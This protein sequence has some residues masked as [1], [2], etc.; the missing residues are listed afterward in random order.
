MDDSSFNNQWHVNYPDDISL[1][2]A[3]FG[4][5]MKQYS[6]D[7]PT[8]NFNTSLETYSPT[9]VIRPAKMLKPN[10]YNACKTEPVSNPEP[11]FSP[12]LLSFG[13]S[14][15]LNQMEMMKPKEEAVFGRTINSTIP[16]DM[17]VAQASFRDPN[18]EFKACQG[19]KKIS[20]NTRLSH[21]QDH[22][23]AERKRREKLSQRFIALS[24]VI[25]G[26][27]KMD[28]ASVLGDAIKYVKQL[29][30]RVKTL[31][32]AKRKKTIESVVLVKKSQ[33]FTTD[34]EKSS[35]DDSKG[36]VDEPLPE[37]EAR[38]CD[39]QVLIRIHCEKRSGV[40]EKIV[41]EIEKLHL[42][43]INNSVLTFGNSA[44]DVTVIA[45]MESGFSISIK[46]L[47]KNLRS[48]F[49]LFV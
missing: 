24:A 42:T 22:I 29:Q 15:H 41:A 11:A 17:L 18:Y 10:A 37:I 49:E 7:D 33:I 13:G 3:A 32:E 21:S 1:L 40:V 36:P 43:L 12:R 30:E 23:E 19:P 14:N 35:C 4:D 20:T 8:S 27:K 9:S 16:P 44:L 28:K 45:Q 38:F 48:S 2:A 26:L 5:D 25:P 46:D 31:E 47:V 6:F 39:K 34:D